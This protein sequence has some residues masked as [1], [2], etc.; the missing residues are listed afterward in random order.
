MWFPMRNFDQTDYQFRNSVCN[1]GYKEYK[2]EEGK[3]KGLLIEARLS[4]NVI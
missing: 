2:T 1:V 3:L 4:D